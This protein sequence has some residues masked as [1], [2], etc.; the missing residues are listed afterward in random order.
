MTT[1]LPEYFCGSFSASA[2]ATRRV[3]PPMDSPRLTTPDESAA[4]AS[5]LACCAVMRVLRGRAGGAGADEQEG[6][7]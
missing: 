7:E 4:A 2:K 5:G 6:S 3:S 1:G